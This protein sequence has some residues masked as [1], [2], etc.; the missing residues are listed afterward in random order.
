AAETSTG[1][2]NG[3]QRVVSVAPAEGQ[4]LVNLAPASAAMLT[5]APP[6]GR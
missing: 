3:P 6:S 5:L 4:Y 1:E 2:L